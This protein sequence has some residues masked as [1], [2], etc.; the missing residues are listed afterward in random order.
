MKTICFYLPQFH[1]IPEN[2]EW[3]GIGFTEWVNVVQSRP[4]FKSHYQPH[5]PADLG[6]YDLRL[7]ETRIQQAK[8]A[9]KYGI[10]GFCYYHYWF[11]GKLLLEKPFNDVLISGKPDFP[12]CLCWANENWTRAWD[13]RD[14]HVLI[15]QEYNDQDNNAH[16]LWLLKAFQDE[17]YIKISNCP[18][19]LIYRIDQIKEITQLIKQWRNTVKFFGFPDIYLCA[20]K[21]N[22][23]ELSD[24]QIL[25]LGFNAIVD[26]QPNKNDY[27]KPKKLSTKF[28]SSIKKIVPNK[29]FQKFKNSLNTAYVLDYRAMAE[30]LI[31][32]NWPENYIKFPCIFPSWDN[33][34]RKKLAT[35]IQNQDPEI[36]EKWLCYAIKCIKNYP[37]SEQLVFLNAWNEW[38]E[39]CHLEPDKRMGHSFLKA[40]KNAL[41]RAE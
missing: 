5:I 28:Y 25:S 41:L 29:I 7:E 10:Y 32:K 33:S 35:I 8:L 3:W 40:T 19:L 9:R 36:Y 22:F 30:G 12:F 17:R 38:A 11:N 2:D 1:P 23:T 39:G 27:P 15:S 6:F 26:F 20:V 21:N 37:E 31:K 18:V 14:H 24:Q 16:I 4:R 13:G 34:S